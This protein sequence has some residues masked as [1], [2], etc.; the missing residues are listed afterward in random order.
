MKDLTVAELPEPKK[1]PVDVDVPLEAMTEP[2]ITDEEAIKTFERLGLVEVS[3]RNVRDLAHIGTYLKGVGVLKIQ[4]GR[5]MM[6][7]QLVY[8]NM[9]VASEHMAAIKNDPKIKPG[10]KTNSLVRCMGALAGLIR[11]ANDSQRVSIEIESST[12]AT[13][14]PVADGPPTVNSFAAKAKIQPVGTT[15][16][17]HGPTQV[18]VQPK[19]A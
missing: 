19:P 12:V 1:P 11:A 14:A 13:G 2:T 8:E 18:L 15:I 9:R 6:T 4:R 17:N 10:A 16:H 3:A 7:Q 5:A